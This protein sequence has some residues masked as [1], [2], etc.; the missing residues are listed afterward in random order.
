MFDGN[1]KYLSIL[2]S[3]PLLLGS[4]AL[5]LLTIALLKKG[6][7]YGKFAR[8]SIIALQIICF[9]IAIFL[10]YLAFAFGSPQPPALPHLLE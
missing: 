10:V 4:T 3:A 1:E 2:V 5:I 9:G 7:H 6:Q 8:A